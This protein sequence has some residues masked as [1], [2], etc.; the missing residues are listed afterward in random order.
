MPMNQ[1]GGDKFI[2]EIDGRQE[3]LFDQ[4]DSSMTNSNTVKQNIFSATSPN[5]SRGGFAQKSE[6]SLIYQ[7]LLSYYKYFRG[8]TSIFLVSYTIKGNNVLL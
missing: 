5:E 6:K 4:P 1:N 7:Q 3:E 8:D 2:N